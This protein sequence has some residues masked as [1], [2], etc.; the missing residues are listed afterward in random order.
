[1]VPPVRR[2]ATGAAN[3]PKTRK[4]FRFVPWSRCIACSDRGQPA[5]KSQWVVTVSVCS[6][7]RFW[8]KKSG[9]NIV[10]RHS[11]G[12]F[13]IASCPARRPLTLP[14]RAVQTGAIRVPALPLA[15]LGGCLLHWRGVC[16]HYTVC[17]KLMA[18]QVEVGRGGS[19]MWRGGVACRCGALTL[20][21]LRHGPREGPYATRTR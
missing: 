2:P 19:G 5:G 7:P 12:P 15:R 9:K 1:M 3:S 6:A 16:M 18:P 11:A 8:Q 14:T 10:L 20:D 4:T 17:T 21:N 13:V